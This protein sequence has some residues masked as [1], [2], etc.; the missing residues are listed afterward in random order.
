MASVYKFTGKF[1][2]DDVG[3]VWPVATIRWCIIEVFLCT[4][5]ITALNFLEFHK[6]K[7]LISGFPKG[8]VVDSDARANDYKDDKEDKDKKDKKDEKKKDSVDVQSDEF[9]E[10]VEKKSKDDK[11]DGESDQGSLGIKPQTATASSLGLKV[12]GSE[13]IN[14]YDFI[15]MLWLYLLFHVICLGVAFHKAYQS[16]IIALWGYLHAASFGAWIFLHVTFKHPLF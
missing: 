13:D 5:A 15:H 8:S 11:K 3:P 14:D 16:G 2:R 4:V 1:T 6:K 7:Q 9:D 10:K 12:N